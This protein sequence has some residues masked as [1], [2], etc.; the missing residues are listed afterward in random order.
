VIEIVEETTEA[1]LVII[2][3]LTEESR[4][5]AVRLEELESLV[6]T[7]GANV[8]GSLLIPLRSVEPA[9]LIGSGKVEEL[10][11]LIAERS[12]NTVIFDHDLSPRAQR[13]LERILEIAVIDRQEVILQIFSNRA[14]TKEAILQVALA[15]QEYSL[16]RLERM[17]SHLSRQRG[18]MRGTRDAGE[19]QLEIDRRTVTNRIASLKRQLKK[20]EE[21]RFIQRKGRREGFIPTAAIVGYTNAGKSSL[22][23][24]LAASDALVENKLFATLDPTTRQIQLPQGAQL[25]LSDTVGFVSNLPHQLIEA[26]KSTL[27]EAKFSDFLIHVVDASHPAMLASFETTREVLESLG[28]KDK[29]MVLFINKMDKLYDNYAVDELRGRFPQAIVGSIKQQA[30]IEELLEAIEKAT[31]YYYP[32]RHLFFPHSRYDLISQLRNNGL[33]LSIDY[34]NEGVKVEAHVPKHLTPIYE[35]YGQN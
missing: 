20:V 30:G 19:T 6:T 21:Q 15:R 11:E 5:S 28:C 17:W 12:A 18:G 8:V 34:L 13:N 29:L 16:P 33:I 31:I 3:E 23:N 10:K 2:R 27:E 26:F 1:L 32:V 9:T 7:M 35:Q 25:L 24:L 14:Q 4:L 22:L